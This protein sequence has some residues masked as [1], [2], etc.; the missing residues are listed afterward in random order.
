MMKGKVHAFAS[1]RDV[2]AGEMSRAMPE[3][4]E[5]IGRVIK[6]TNEKVEAVVKKEEL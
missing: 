6:T 4:E 3:L 5:D 1:F 2:L